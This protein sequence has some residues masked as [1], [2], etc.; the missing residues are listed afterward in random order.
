M[1]RIAKA[2]VHAA[3][4]RVA[5]QISQADGGDGRIS[6]ADMKEKLQDMSGTE[7]ALADIFFRFIDHRD[8]KPG[9][10][11]T[12]KDVTRALE[13]SKEKLIDKYDL[14]NNGLSKSEISE[15]SRTGQLAVLLAQEL[16][17]ADETPSSGKALANQF[18]MIADGLTYTSEADYPYEAVHLEKP[19]S[20]KNTLNSFRTALHIPSDM[21]VSAGPVG[22]FFQVYDRE[23]DLSPDELAEQ[24]QYDDLAK[25]MGKLDNL[26]VIHV[27][28]DDVVEGKIYIVGEAP[29][30]SLAGLSTTRIWT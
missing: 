23:D 12:A 10:T 28:G 8:Y 21:E 11:V 9:A 1:S 25:A 29:D 26:Q 13:Y 19:T 15:M 14:N 7:R 16:K 20:G 22:D 27:G 2:D 4:A 30:G 5:Q 17:G 3:L 24:A 18:A 6:R